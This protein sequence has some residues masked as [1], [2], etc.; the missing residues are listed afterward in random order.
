M[1]TD[2]RLSKCNP[3][4]GISDDVK[5][6]EGLQQQGPECPMVS[7][8]TFLTLPTLKSLKGIGT[9]TAK[10]LIKKIEWMERIDAID[11]IE[12]IEDKYNQEDR[13]YI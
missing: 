6:A 3:F 1:L 7:L 5:K 11:A 12:G 10:D 8:P 2:H 13:C 4:R 9:P